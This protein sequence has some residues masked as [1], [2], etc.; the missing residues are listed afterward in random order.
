M[1]RKSNSN[2]WPKA[3]EVLVWLVPTTRQGTVPRMRLTPPS[4]LCSSSCRLVSNNLGKPL[5]TCLY[6]VKPMIRHLICATLT[7]IPC[8]GLLLADSDR[9]LLSSLHT[10]LMFCL[11]TSVGHSRIT[12]QFTSFRQTNTLEHVQNPGLCPLVCQLSL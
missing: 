6:L 9:T 11:I 3:P 10:N 2:W 4:L 12:C 1:S 8:A 7:S 5:S